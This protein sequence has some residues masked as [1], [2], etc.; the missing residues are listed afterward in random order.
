MT[1]GRREA[2]TEPTWMY[3]RRVMLSRLSQ[4]A[5]PAKQLTTAEMTL[6]HL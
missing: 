1:V 3:S 6:G 5:L 2:G 4:L